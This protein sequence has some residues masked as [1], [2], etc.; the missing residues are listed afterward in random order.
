MKHF[1]AARV[2]VVGDTR[3]R[4]EGMTL[5]SRMG[6]IDELDALCLIQKQKEIYVHKL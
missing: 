2:V 1:V 6:S 4:N 3:K 5:C